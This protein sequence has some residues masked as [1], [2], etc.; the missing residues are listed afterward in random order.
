MAPPAAGL[1]AQ[2]AWWR[3]PKVRQLIAQ[4]LV[5][6]VTVWVVHALVQ[7]T[8]ANFADRSIKTTFT[9]LGEAATFAIPLNFHPLWEFVLGESVYWDV[10][11]I[12][13]QNTVIV[14]ALGIPAAALV[15]VVVGIVLL[16]PNWI[17]AKLARTYVEVLRNTPLLLQLLFWHF[18]VFPPI[19]NSLPPVRESIISGGAVIN[20]AGIYLPMPVVDD[21]AG[22]VLA[23]LL[24]AFAAGCVAISRWVRRQQELTGRQYSAPLFYLALAVGLVVVFFSVV[25]DHFGIE[26]P[27][28]KG[29]NF[30]GGMRPPKELISLWF[31]LVV[32]TSS[33]IAENVRGGILAVSTGQNEAAMALGLYRRQRMKLVILPQALRV[34]IPPTI[35][36]FLNL[37]K[38][39][40]LAVAVG[41]PDITNIWL[42]I[43]LNQTGQAVII[44]LMTVAVYET[45]NALTSLATNLYNRRVQ[46]AER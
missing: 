18:A 35:S 37:I 25:G 26:F 20:S 15:G 14:A 22:W 8:Q 19:F 7:N 34:I 6:V 11:I 44:V 39:S 36:Q 43:A 9:F 2:V 16:S 30:R 27:E 41:Y 32:Y 28:K 12:G 46:I 21:F 40:S 4:A 5:V 13:I 29:L 42:G 17:L 38:N 33:Y 31:G 1:T 10:F 23:A 24:A 3:N 45:L